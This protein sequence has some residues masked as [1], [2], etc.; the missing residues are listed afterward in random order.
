MEFLMIILVILT[1]FSPIIFIIGLIMCLISKEKTG[2]DN[3]VKL[4]IYSSIAFTI[5]F[6]GCL[7]VLS[8]GNGFH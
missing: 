2:R 8:N 3:G 4:L 5:G 6:G 7:V 1:C